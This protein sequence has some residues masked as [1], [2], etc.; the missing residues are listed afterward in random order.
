MNIREIKQH[1]KLRKVDM[2]FTFDEQLSIKGR[3][4][5][6]QIIIIHTMRYLVLY[7]GWSQLLPLY[8]FLTF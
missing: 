8:E 3:L 6:V 4:T 2:C 7:R 1:I 5:R